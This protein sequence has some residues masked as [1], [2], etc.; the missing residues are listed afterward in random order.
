L[1]IALV[2]LYLI[3]ARQIVKDIG[4]GDSSSGRLAGAMQTHVNR[5]SLAIVSYLQ[6]H[7]PGDLERI[8]F[9]EAEVNRLLSELR[10]KTP[11][12]GS[13]AAFAQVEKAYEAI[14]QAAAELRQEDQGQRK[15]QEALNAA[16]EALMS[17]MVAR[18]EPSI[19]PSQLKS[20]ARLQA[21]LAAAAEA[22]S[23]TKTPSNAESLATSQTRFHRAMETYVQLSGTR[24][25]RVWAAEASALFDQCIGLAQ[26]VQRAEEK[27]Q[28]DLDGFTQKQ[29]DFNVV[30]QENR[31]FQT[32][33]FQF[34]S[35]GELFTSGL[36]SVLAGGIL[37]LFGL[38]FCLRRAIGESHRS[39]QPSL[40]NILSCVEAAASGDVSRVPES[41]SSDEAGQLAQAVSRLIQVLARSENLVY[42]LAALVESSGE[43]II[44]HTLDGAILSWN[45]GAQRIYGYSAD[46]MKGQS[47]FLLAPD[48]EAEMEHY[49]R[50]LSTGEQLQPFEVT[51][52]AR[53][54]RSINVLVRV[55]AI[56][57]ST[58]KIIGASFCAQDM[59]GTEVHPVSAL[60]EP[61][62]YS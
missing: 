35:A 56:F 38:V 50:R 13:D 55:S 30:L 42:H 59:T 47:I 31:L 52:R 51:H 23:V 43:A 32:Q 37:L 49:L 39:S 15:Q 8:R 33:G 60:E 46:E 21:V 44:S 45:K 9:E 24:R 11:R 5:I 53:N 18:M 17:V 25:A 2:P 40:R 28:A 1:F 62:T 27:K 29:N 14:Q 20:S 41:T 19:K 58:R 61:R 12:S 54:G 36:V 7:N 57:D 3:Q 4:V 26:E 48:A 34:S 16:G 6:I 22:K 10:D